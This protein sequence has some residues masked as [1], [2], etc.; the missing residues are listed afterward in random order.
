MPCLIATY[1]IKHGGKT[2]SV[3]KGL[4]RDRA[5]DDSSNQIAVFGRV[6]ARPLNFEEQRR[7]FFHNDKLWTAVDDPSDPMYGS[8]RK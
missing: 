5:V 2:L 7:L 3:A 4:D 1:P 8:P 6:G